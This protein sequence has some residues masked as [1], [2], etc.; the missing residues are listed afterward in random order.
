MSRTADAGSACRRNGASHPGGGRTT[1]LKFKTIG[2]S[3]LIPSL[4]LDAVGSGVASHLTG[5]IG[6]FPEAESL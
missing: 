1:H 2:A 4:S 3:P 6:H 5:S